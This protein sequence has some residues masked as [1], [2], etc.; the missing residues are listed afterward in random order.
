MK[1]S[2]YNN[3]ITEKDGEYLYYNSGS[4]AIAWLEE[5]AHNAILHNNF[6][7]IDK[8][9]LAALEK[10]GLI[11]NDAVDEYGRHMNRSKQFKM[12]MNS[13]LSTFVIAPTMACNLRCVYCFECGRYSNEKMSEETQ[14]NVFKFIA[15]TLI[16]RKKKRIK[17]TWFGGEPMLAYPVIKNLSSKL[18][19][20]CDKHE[21]EYS[22][23]MVTNGTLLS[24]EI[25]NDLA[26]KYRFKNIQ[27]T[28][29]GDSHW[30]KILK[31][32]TD[33]HFNDVI[34]NI[35]TV[36][37]SPIT[38]ALRLNVCQENVN[39]FKTTIERLL[40]NQDFHAYIYAGK[41]LKYSDTDIFN[42][43]SNE[44]IN[45]LKEYIKEKTKGF[46]EYKKLYSKKL[47]P[48][49]ASCGYMV[50]GRGLIDH[51]GLI[52]RCEHQINNKDF[53]IGDVVNGFYYN[54]V[55]CAFIDYVLPEKCK[56]CSIMP[57]CMGGCVSDTVFENKETNCESIKDDIFHMVKTIS[58]I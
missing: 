28:I 7:S 12:D 3:V 10:N 31:K 22:A 1:K 17:I 51:N 26:Y 6:T 42:E 48:K 4:G 55:D 38:L 41:L 47:E 58:N 33:K 27:I 40:E 8:E 25:V 13:D 29:D 45:A 36:A 37:K 21:I 5:N 14:E 44:D 49:G 53:A 35:I 18:I 32:G 20:F 16:A 54:R 2:I 50:D 30:Y 39:N 15:N 24:E 57:V 19:E 34:N 56:I 46:P 43:V 11:V 23:S 52:Y 9:L